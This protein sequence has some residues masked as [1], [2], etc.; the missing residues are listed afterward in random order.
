MVYFYQAFLK[1]GHLWE[2]GQAL[3]FALQETIW[4][5]SSA[6]YL[7]SFPELC[8]FL[9]DI[10]KWIEYAIF[11]LIF[12]PFLNKWGRVAGGI[13]L[14]IL[15][16]TIFVFL[17]LGLFPLIVPMFVL[18]LFPSE[19]YDRL[20]TFFKRGKKFI[21]PTKLNKFRFIDSKKTKLISNIV[22]VSMFV[23][24]NWKASLTIPQI[25]E[26]LPEIGFIKKIN[27]SSLFFQYWGFYCP[28][29]SI[30]HGWY[31]VAG[32]TEQGKRID[33]KNGSEMSFD[34]SGLAPYRNY[35]WLVFYYKT[36]LYGYVSSRPLLNKWAKFEYD[37][38]VINQ[39]TENFVQIQI[40]DFRQTILS[41]TEVS[42]IET[43][44]ISYAQY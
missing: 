3:S 36:I 44:I 38:T 24:I 35:S 41:P 19:F 17:D 42:K 33:L 37:Q 16:W 7:L 11:P 40:V 1:S 10:T 29:P 13:L 32:V 39:P 15:H 21:T 27:H 18:L 30:T 12:L 2:N 43:G 4:A 20:E 8:S 14:L 22:L 31:K 26:K 5:K 9:T 23:L 6:S 34:D 28:N 25:D